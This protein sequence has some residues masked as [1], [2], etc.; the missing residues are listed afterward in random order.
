MKINVKKTKVMCISRQ[1]GRKVRI[2][3]DGQ[4]VEQVNHFKYL[5]S[6]ISED[7]YCEKDVRCRITMAK[8]AFMEKKKLLT[9]KLNMDLK[10]R[11][12]K[13][14]IWGVALYAAETWT[15]T[16]TSR[17]KLEAFESWV[18]RR[19]LKICWTEKITNE[20]VRKRICE[21]KKYI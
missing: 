21:E 3:I 14:T 8:N 20:E 9:S 12:I 19:M 2:L 1:G 16:E 4:K 5:G 17:K 7:G 10:K 6:V 13:S 18:W 15:L 11:I